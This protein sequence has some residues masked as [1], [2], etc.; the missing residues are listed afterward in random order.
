MNTKWAPTE[1]MSE[2]GRLEVWRDR[3]KHIPRALPAAVEGEEY[4]GGWEGALGDTVE[5]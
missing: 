5:Q 1:L 4:G 2:W 3:E